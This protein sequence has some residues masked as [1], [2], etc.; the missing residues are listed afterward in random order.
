MW[1]QEEQING[2][3]ETAFT[4]YVVNVYIPG[5]FVSILYFVDRASRYIRVMK[6]NLNHY[7]SSVYFVNQPLHDS[8]IYVAHHQEV[9][10]IYT[11]IVMCCAF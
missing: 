6:T 9:F 4:Q 1:G 7:L 10:C 8:V 3:N 11:I 5:F 2:L